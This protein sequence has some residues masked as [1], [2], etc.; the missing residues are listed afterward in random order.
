MVMK[1]CK[2]MEEIHE[3]GRVEGRAEGRVEGRAEGIAETTF[4]IV[5]NLLAGRDM[6]YERIAQAADTSVEE[7][8]R[9]AKESGLAY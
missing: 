1:M 3:D 7:V 6:P 8:A 9:I 4:K 2:S 5:R